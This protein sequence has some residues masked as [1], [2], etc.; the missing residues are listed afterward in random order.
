MNKLL[1][2]LICQR[3]A[4]A[5]LSKKTLRSIDL[6]CLLSSIYVSPSRA[7]WDLILGHDFFTHFYTCVVFIYMEACFFK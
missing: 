1:R 5:Q 4:G 2:A 7:V 6:H 3:T